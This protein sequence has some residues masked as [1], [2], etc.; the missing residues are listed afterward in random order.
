MSWQKSYLIEYN[1]NIN[2]SVKMFE[3][4]YAMTGNEQ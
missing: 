3:K 4:L 2:I 1:I